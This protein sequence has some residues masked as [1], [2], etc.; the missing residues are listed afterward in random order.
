MSRSGNNFDEGVDGDRFPLADATWADDKGNT[1]AI[2]PSAGVT[3]GYNVRRRPAAPAKPARVRKTQPAPVAEEAAPQAATPAAAPRTEAFRGIT[4][5]DVARF[6]LNFRRAQTAWCADK[7]ERTA[8]ESA[9]YG[10]TADMA[11]AAMIFER[12]DDP[13]AAADARAVDFR[14]TN[15]ER[16]AETA[17]RDAARARLLAAEWEGAATYGAYRVRTEERG[18]GIVAV[19]VR[20]N[21]SESAAINRAAA[22]YARTL[23]LKTGGAAGGGEFTGKGAE[24]IAQ[25]IFHRP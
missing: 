20:G 1:G 8:E 11:S 3:A 15:A 23:G 10:R 9:V 5:A 6:T 14:I 13:E 21:A 24:Y 17:R 18:H 2:D 22:S 7:R 4:R 12:E 25:G 16:A 19:Y